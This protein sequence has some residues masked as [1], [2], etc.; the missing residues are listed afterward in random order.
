M[1]YLLSLAPRVNPATGLEWF[2]L[3]P[4]LG[5]SHSTITKNSNTAFG[6][7]GMMIV[8]E[9]RANKLKEGAQDINLVEFVRRMSSD[10]WPI[11]AVCKSLISGCPAGG[12]SADIQDPTCPTC[13]GPAL[14]ANEYPRLVWGN[15]YP[16]LQVLKRQYD[17]TNVFRFPQSVRAS[18]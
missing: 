17:P 8:W 5:G 4:Y 3:S 12:V 14:T 13:L 7:R 10:L 1:T 18:R 9:L 6:H 16:R 15:A 2:V 11:Q